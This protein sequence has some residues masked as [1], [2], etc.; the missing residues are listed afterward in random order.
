MRKMISRKFLFSLVLCMIL[1]HMSTRWAYED[2]VFVAMIAGAVVVACTWIVCEAR[3]DRAAA[4]INLPPEVTR[5]VDKPP[6]GDGE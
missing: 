3:V 5:R 6:E 1:I 4:P 2:W